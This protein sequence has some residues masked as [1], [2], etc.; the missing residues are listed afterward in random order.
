[1]QISLAEVKKIGNVELLAKQVV[2]GFITGLHK[3]PYHGFSVEFAE[4][5][6]YNN[7]D[8]TRYIDWKVYAKT[9]KLFTKRFEEETNLRCNILI[10]TSSSMYYPHV[11]NSKITFSLMAAGCLIQLLQRQRDAVGITLFSEEIHYQSEI[12]S[13]SSH[14]HQLFIKLS[15]QLLASAKEV[16]TSLSNTLDHIAETQHKRSLLIIFSDMYDNMT[17]LDKTLDGL[18]HLKHNKHEVLIFHVVDKKSELEFEFEDRPYQFIDLESGQKI[19]LNPSQ[20]RDQY[21]KSL[22]EEKNKLVAKCEQYKITL[23]EADINDG[24]NKVMIDFLVKRAKMR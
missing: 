11:D 12:K 22:Q 20:V 6:L 7:G 5:R 2:E 18:Q 16:K 1:M 21:L 14:Q 13:T 23:I 3:S 24:W 8:S 10:D 17:D 19:K 15:Q 9:D 4:H